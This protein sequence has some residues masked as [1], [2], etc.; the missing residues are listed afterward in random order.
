M[1]KWIIKIM[2]AAGVMLMLLVI[3]VMVP[4]TIPK[5][6][7]YQIYGVLTGS[8]EPS[9]PVGSALFIKPCGIGEIVVGD[10]V[11]YTLGSG[12]DYV[13]SHR[14]IEIA[15]QEN[16]LRTKGDA[17]NEADPEPVNTER[18]I[19]KAVLTVPGLGRAAEYLET[20]S[21]K[22]VCFILFAVSFILWLTADMFARGGQQRKS[23]GEGTEKTVRKGGKN[24]SV[25]AV[26]AVGCLLILGSALYLGRILLEYHR[27]E[28]E[29]DSLERQVFAENI[30]GSEDGREDSGTAALQ[31]DEAARRESWEAVCRGIRKL[32]EENKD[33]IGWITFDNVDI[34]YPIM[35]GAD[36]DE[37]LYHTYSGVYNSSGSIFMEALNSPDF[38]DNHTI[39]YG[40]NMKNGSMFG[41]LKKYR[42]QDF[43]KENAFFTVY[44]G[45]KMYR[46]EIFAYYDISE[47]GDVYQIAFPSAED[48]GRLIAGMQKRS[49]YDTG[50]PVSTGDKLITLSTCSTEGNRF[51]VNAKRI[52]EE[53]IIQGN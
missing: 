36:N 2:N 26:R 29:Y 21:G 46:Y 51:V 17:N 4:F 44:T 31:D 39:L 28:A 7:G 11:T 5:L 23:S 33:V 47:Y 1:K 34:S 42:Q 43:Y 15:E 38:Q 30:R 14:V 41:K 18:L 49:Y 3:A 10:V 13:M 40:H 52:A 45:E 37:Y 24:A 48:F 25:W 35:Q 6:F 16:L 32:Q 12:T 20:A 9:I 50:I 19:G 53:D 8:M 22:A 27:G